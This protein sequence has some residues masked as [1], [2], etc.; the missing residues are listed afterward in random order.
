MFFWQNGDVLY[1]RAS[2]P[3]EMFF[4]ASGF[5]SWSLLLLS[6]LSCRVLSSTAPRCWFRCFIVAVFQTLNNGVLH[7]LAAADC[8]PLRCRQ[9]RLLLT[10]TALL[11]SRSSCTS[12]VSAACLS[13][14][15]ARSLSRS[16]CS[17]FFYI[18]PLPCLDNT[19]VMSLPRP[20]VYTLLTSGDAE[21]QAPPRG[22][23]PPRADGGLDRP[24]ELR[25]AQG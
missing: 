6:V 10:R 1:R 25:E 8:E 18:L 22:V 24:R 14:V 17:V 19:L 11:S 15:R 3:E 7:R 13:K 9:A 12:L 20:S 5:V 21:V 16:P 2:Q 23:P 4:I